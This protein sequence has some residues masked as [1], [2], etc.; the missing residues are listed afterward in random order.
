MAF[1]VS[2]DYTSSQAINRFF[3]CR[4]RYL[5][6]ISLLLLSKSTAQGFGLAL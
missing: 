6:R 4:N 3:P 1:N 5:A 2:G